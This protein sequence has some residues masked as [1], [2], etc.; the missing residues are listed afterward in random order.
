MRLGASFAIPLLAIAASAH[1][2]AYQCRIPQ[3]PFSVSTPQRDGPV[4]QTRIAGYTLALSWAPEFC[5]GREGR[6]A[7]RME[8]SGNFGRFGLVLHGLW[9]EGVGGSSPQW[10]PTTHRPTPSQ[11]RAN[12]CMTPSAK[13]LEHEWAKHGACITHT[14]GRYFEL[15]HKLWDALGFPDLDRLSRRKGLTTGML[16]QAFVE[17]NPAFRA[18]Q[19]GLEV[20]QRGWLEGM[21]L[22]YD[23]RFRPARCTRNQLG[24]ADDTKLKIWRGL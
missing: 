6:A 7:D 22:C 8:C 16:R 13:L 21:R 15:A 19:V 12:L 2:Q 1:A 10:C 18:D 20:N 24:P 9:P 11:I 3:G 17:A 14:P 23:K 5:H 4:R